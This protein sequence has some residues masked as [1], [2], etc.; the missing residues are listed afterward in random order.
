MHLSVLAGH[1]NPSIWTDEAKLALAAGYGVDEIVTATFGH[2]WGWSGNES[3]M[4]D[5]L[6]TSFSTLQS[7]E[8]ERI[9]Q[10]GE[11]GEARALEW[12]NEARKRERA[13]RVRGG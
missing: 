10:I 12:R 1:P 3:D 4:W 11:R 6:A 8:E 2:S 13:E 5:G 7:H 9:R